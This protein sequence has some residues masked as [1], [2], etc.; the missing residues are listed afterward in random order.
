MPKWRDCLRTSSHERETHE[1]LLSKQSDCEEKIKLITKKHSELTP[2]QFM[3]VDELNRHKLLMKKLKKR[4]QKIETLENILAEKLV[5]Y[6]DEAK[7]FVNL[8]ENMMT[9]KNVSNENST[10]SSESSVLKNAIQKMNNLN[11]DLR[12][13]LL[14]NSNQDCISVTMTDSQYS[15]TEYKKK[16]DSLTSKF[17]DLNF[18]NKI[19][20]EKITDA[21]N[22]V[23]IAQSL[24]EN[25]KLLTSI[26]EKGKKWDSVVSNIEEDFYRKQKQT[27]L[28]L[29]SFFT[30]GK[31][32]NEGSCHRC[33]QN[34]AFVPTAVLASGLSLCI[35][36]YEKQCSRHEDSD[37]KT[38]QLSHHAPV[39]RPKQLVKES[40]D[41]IFPAIH[42][43]TISWYP[44]P[45][46]YFF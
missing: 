30:V 40:N 29:K 44:V 8:K 21:E 17:Q 11:L 46:C 14:S 5:I 12:G 37:L 45:G 13:A 35:W 43:Y 7:K 19:M 26:V 31:E 10:S 9:L 20:R 22:D 25:T 18:E 4:T 28:D 39:F 23:F 16:L 34:L 2:R 6:E 24:L 41:D 32:V 36:C 33:F 3:S 38:K 42:F 27:L 15:L 1:K